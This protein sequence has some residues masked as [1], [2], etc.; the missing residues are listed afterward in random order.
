QVVGPGKDQV[1]GLFPAAPA[2]V[3]P[4]V[5]R[6]VERPVPLEVEEGSAEPAVVIEVAVGRERPLLPMAEHEHDLLGPVTADRLEEVGI[7][8]ELQQEAGF[9]GARELGVPRSVVPPAAGA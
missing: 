6:T 2:A 7:G 4:R 3:E 5:R 8:A 9:G 1:S